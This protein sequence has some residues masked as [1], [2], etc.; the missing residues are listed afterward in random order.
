MTA[1]VHILACFLGMLSL[2]A[3]DSKCKLDLG[4]VVDTTKSIE[5]VNVPKLK[6]ALRL[7]VQQFN[8]SEDRTHV[9]LETFH[10][11]STIHNYF[12]NTNFY[13][14]KALLDLI[15]KAINKLKQPTRLDYA[16]QKAKEMFTPKSG[17]RDGVRNVMVLFTDG[18]SHPNTQD[19]QYENAVKDLKAKGVRLVVVGI[20]PGARRNKYRKVLKKIGGD[21]VFYAD[22]YD[23]LGEA[24][25]NITDL[26]CP[27]TCE[28]S[29]GLDVA[30]LVDKTKS[31]GVENF[32]L[33]KGFLLQLADALTIGP[34]A[35]HV[36][37]IL[38]AKRPELLNTFGD[39]KYHSGEKVTSLVKGIPIKLSSPTFIDRALME[40]NVSLFTK[41]G[42][43]RP[44]FPNVL[45]LFTD[46][47]TNKASEP[48][49]KIIPSLEGK[50]VKRVAVG[51]GK[52]KNFAG[53]LQEIAGDN[54]Y[55]ASSFEELSDLFTDIMAEVC[56][57]DGGFSRWSDW[58]YCNDQGVETRTRT[59]TNPPRRGDGKDCEGDRMETRPCAKR[60]PGVSEFQQQRPEQERNWD[61]DPK[62]FRKLREKI[63][64]S[65][66]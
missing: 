30:F 20:G 27:S 34:K 13:T 64:Q 43:Y 38:F 18:R 57:V 19:V 9:S 62:F 25:K 63:L 65:D 5:K 55:N 58:S 32:K 24:M 3:A 45:I 10:K 31:V 8:V 17:D 16:L 66:E 14:E 41:E 37:Y 52:Y 22:D 6:E 46:G 12:N 47:K 53:Q 54:V 42:G 59:C 56:N 26:I 4:L 51:I 33:L 21:N 48:F 39:A 11:E 60:D 29:P 7:L 44:D 49:S 40:A 36:G 2:T 61:Y 15:N 1:L 35:T 23:N 50:G 28:D